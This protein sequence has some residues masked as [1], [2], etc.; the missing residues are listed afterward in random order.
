MKLKARYEKK[1]VDNK[2]K[3]KE[4]IHGRGGN[5]NTRNAR[6]ARM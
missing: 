2:K 3:R 1:R 6:N 4:K 5:V